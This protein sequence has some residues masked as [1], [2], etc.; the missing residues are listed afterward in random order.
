VRRAAR[1]RYGARRDCGAARGA[2]AVR[3]AARLR[4]QEDDGPARKAFAMARAAAAGTHG[5]TRPRRVR[6]DRVGRVALLF[7]LVV[8]LYLAI[9]PVRALFSD[10]HV[11]AQRRAQ[12]DALER[13]HA[14][15]VSTERSLRARATADL[16]AR[17]LGLVRPGEREYV[18]SGLPNN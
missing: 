15:L 9:S 8:L 12:L 10:L 7:A 4:E 14:T 11:V 3:R 5:P 6:W 16:E 2:T 18:V 13:E 17:S 1:L